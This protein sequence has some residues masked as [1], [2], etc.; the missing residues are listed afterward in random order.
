MKK[1]FASPENHRD[2]KQKGETCFGQHSQDKFKIFTKLGL[3][4]EKL[5]FLVPGP[6]NNILGDVSRPTGTLITRKTP[7]QL[8]EQCQSVA[9]CKPEHV[10]E[11]W[12]ATHCQSD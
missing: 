11:T 5:I 6:D 2:L 10:L 9:Q 12:P 3:R 7:Q 8:L 4:L 1:Y